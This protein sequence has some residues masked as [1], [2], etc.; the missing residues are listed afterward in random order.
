MAVAA[1]GIVEQR[2]GGAQ[3]DA[4]DVVHGKA[5][6]A[7]DLVERVDIDVILD[8]LHHGLGFLSGV[9]QDEL[10]ARRH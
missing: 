4:P 5:I 10:G 7:L 3:A 9:A 1:V 8:L 6:D 2:H